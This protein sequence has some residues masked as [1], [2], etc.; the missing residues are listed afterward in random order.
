M[1]FVAAFGQN[2]DNNERDELSSIVF[3]DLVLPNTRTKTQ[4]K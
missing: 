2:S 4:E 1:A 3:S